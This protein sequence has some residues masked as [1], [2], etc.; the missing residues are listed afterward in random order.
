M[1]RLEAA[2]NY[3]KEITDAK[4]N[5]G[6]SDLSGDQAQDGEQGKGGADRAG[7]DGTVPENRQKAT[8]PALLK[9]TLRKALRKA[10]QNPVVAARILR[11]SV[12]DLNREIE[13]SGQ[14]G[15]YLKEIRQFERKIREEY[16]TMSLR[17]VEED[18]K[19]RAALYRSEALDALYDLAK[20][21][22][23]A[24]T[25]SALAQ[26]KLMAAQRLYQETSDA[27]AGPGEIEST[28]R[29]LNERFQEAAPR[30]KQIRERIIQFEN[31]ASS[32]GQLIDATSD[33]G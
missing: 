24:K 17:E 29:I 7:Q 23:N 31:N 32:Q 9:Q 28:L 19:C 3:S 2:L 15:K 25:N 8:Y 13:M 4:R 26:V 18:L 1:G 27:G 5:A 10:N 12:S 14:M 11:M 21:E 30:I 33:S 22:V 6:R 16:R 20:M